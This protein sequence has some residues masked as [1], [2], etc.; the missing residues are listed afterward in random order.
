MKTEKYAQTVT[1]DNIDDYINN[2]AGSLFL[3]LHPQYQLSDGST[4]T[5]EGI[6]ADGNIL[7]NDVAIAPQPLSKE[8]ALEMMETYDM[9]YIAGG[10]NLDMAREAISKRRQEEEMERQEKERQEEE[11]R[12][13]AEEIEFMALPFGF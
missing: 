5:L 2:P 10:S 1:K 3:Y 11:D 13:L 4:D 8:T 12:R 7:I 6:G 9:Y